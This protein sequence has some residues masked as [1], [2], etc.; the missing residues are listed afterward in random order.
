MCGIKKKKAV[1]IERENM[2]ETPWEST[3]MHETQR[4]RNSFTS[5]AV[6]ERAPS[7]PPRPAAKYG[8]AEN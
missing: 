5:E 4:K 6:T 7:A 1:K 2:K 8:R 3:E